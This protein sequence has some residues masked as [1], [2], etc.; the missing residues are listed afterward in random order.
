MQANQE[1]GK[2]IFTALYLPKTKTFYDRMSFIMYYT[3]KHT[4]E[5]GGFD[6]T[7]HRNVLLNSVV[8]CVTAF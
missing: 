4:N 6:M 8:L 1:R 7:T 3:I 2:Y 5:R